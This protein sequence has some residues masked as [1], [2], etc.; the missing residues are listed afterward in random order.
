MSDQ[1][2]Q[3]PPLPAAEFVFCQD[4]I[5]DGIDTYTAEQMRAYADATCELRER[6][7]VRALWRDKDAITDPVTNIPDEAKP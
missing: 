4:I 5:V 1:Q 6:E 3:Y 7:Q 2:K